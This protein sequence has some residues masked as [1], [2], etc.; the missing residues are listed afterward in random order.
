MD[1][2]Q[3]QQKLNLY[4]ITSIEKEFW[5]TRN[6]EFTHQNKSIQDFKHTEI[7]S[8]EIQT[9]EKIYLNK[10]HFISFD[11][12]ENTSIKN[13]L[14][15]LKIT[16]GSKIYLYDCDLSL[17]LK[18]DIK[19]R[20]IY[21]LY[22]FKI[23]EFKKDVNSNN[24]KI[25]KDAM[26]NI[27]ISLIEIQ[28]NNIPQK[29]MN[30][31]EKFD[32][33]VKAIESMNNNNLIDNLLLDTFNEFEE[34]Y[35]NKRA[36]IKFLELLEITKIILKNKEPSDK[37]IDKFINLFKTLL[38]NKLIFFDKIEEK[39]INEFLNLFNNIKEKA[40]LYKKFTIVIN[41]FHGYY[42]ENENL[43]TYLDNEENLL[44]LSELY[45]NSLY[46]PTNEQIKDKL[47]NVLITNSKTLD[48]FFFIIN[49]NE[50]IT[51]KIKE[52]INYF[53]TLK[54]I[55]IET[56]IRYQ[57]PI[58]CIDNIQ[59][60]EK[61]E[62]FVSLHKK[63]VEFEL[64]I[65]SE[66][67][68]K[69]IFNFYEVLKN[70]IK[71]YENLIG[72]KEKLDDLYLLKNAIKEESKINKEPMENLYNYA[73]KLIHLNIIEIVKKNILND[74]EV[75]KIIKSD[76]YFF[77]ELYKITNEDFLI[78]NHFN[79]REHFFKKNDNFFNAFK[80]SQIWKPFCRTKENTKL[81]INTFGDKINDIKYLNVFYL[82]LP[83]ED[84]N[85]QM[86]EE[87]ILWLEKNILTFDKMVINDEKMKNQFISGISNLINLCIKVHYDMDK[88]F[89]F[90]EKFFTDNIKHMNELN[91]NDGFSMINEIF[92]YFINNYNI[93][94]NKSIPINVQNKILSF[95]I[96]NSNYILNNEYLFISFLNKVN[97]DSQHLSLDTLFNSLETFEIKKIDLLSNTENIKLK[98]FEFLINKFK[99]EFD[100]KTNNS[101]YMINTRKTIKIFIIKDIDEMNIIYSDINIMFN[102]GI[103]MELNKKN[104][105]NTFILCSKIKKT[106][107]KQSE[108]NSEQ[109]YESKYNEL[110]EMYIK[111]K[112]IINKL[113]DAIQYFLFF[114]S[115]DEKSTE[116]IK[117]LLNEFNSKKIKDFFTEEN[118]LKLAKY[119]DLFNLSGK[120]CTLKNS[121]CFMNIY[122][123]LLHKYKDPRMKESVNNLNVVDKNLILA[124]VST[125]ISIFTTLKKLF[126]EFNN[127]NN[128]LETFTHHGVRYFYE[129]ELK[130]GE[131]DLKKEIDF[132]INYFTNNAN[133]EHEKNIYAN[134]DKNK[135]VEY[136]KKIIILV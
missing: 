15:L 80:E 47:K 5:K 113:E 54:K 36:K 72:S 122:E 110:K 84:Y 65:A 87:I 135:F 51:N 115:E 8:E 101:N 111:C 23:G 129:L 90:L 81:Y 9:N 106:E 73:N 40:S 89:L 121:S 119:N 2:I 100:N 79:I 11:F 68:K 27:Q 53:N 46:E 114:G 131:G 96:K 98:I 4:F 26:V 97:I 92:I 125:A 38:N 103:N 104:I 126:E 78:L 21:I 88:F 52:I 29:E 39:D 28:E 133:D 109:Y 63:I 45:K 71:L 25:L 75:L 107:K 60:D 35:I 19:T 3:S 44:N 43:L 85:Y 49:K 30:F 31:R 12:P 64:D 117:A 136:I 123:E 95:Y 50:N 76:E 16:N 112:E 130:N 14:I 6:I 102:S 59:S 83:L 66:I 41:L 13:N 94:N 70:Y 42:D 24:G 17:N 134:F 55:L 10:L 22:N 20:D 118:K 1:E 61:P 48:E 116:E 67:K 7:Y 34:I 128:D 93:D 82:I 37:V 69:E 86:T 108:I 99:S 127:H 91:I 105:I 33:F 120:A 132:V 58:N 57:I 18:E 32:F 74:I 62:I 56:D 124:N 77:D